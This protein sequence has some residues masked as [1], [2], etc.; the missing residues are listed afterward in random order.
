M[1]GH[2]HDDAPDTGFSAITKSI[3][4]LSIVQNGVKGCASRKRRM[5]AG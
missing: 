4:S 5:I 2:A 3:V 1:R